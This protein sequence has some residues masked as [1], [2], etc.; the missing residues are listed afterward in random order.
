MKILN[1]IIGHNILSYYKWYISSIYSAK[2]LGYG[3]NHFNVG[4][5][6]HQVSTLTFML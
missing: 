1:F 2:G 6:T 3:I 5:G 4:Y